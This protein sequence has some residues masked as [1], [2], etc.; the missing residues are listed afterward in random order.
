MNEKIRN[1]VRD[2]ILHPTAPGWC[3]VAMG[4]IAA[5]ILAAA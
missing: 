2:A 5:I 3:F 1:T 4:V